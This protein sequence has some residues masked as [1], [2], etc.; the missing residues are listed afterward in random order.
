MPRGEISRFRPEG[1]SFHPDQGNYP[2]MIRFILYIARW[3]L[4]TPIMAPVIAFFTHSERM[5][6]TYQEW[7]AT[8]LGNLLGAGLFF[9]VDRFIFKSEIVESLEKK[10]IEKS[11]SGKYSKYYGT[12]VRLLLYLL[13][14]QL[15][16]LVVAP[17]IAYRLNSGSIF[18]SSQEWFATSMA[19]IVGGLIF[20]WVDKFIFKNQ[21]IEHWDS[22]RSGVCYDCGK[23]GFVRRL[24]Y[25]PGKY[26]RRDD[27]SP[28][29][30]CSSCSRKKL[31]EVRSRINAGVA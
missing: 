18:G 23:S 13:R 9:W 7:S 19:N 12:G 6:G 4:S 22:I 15:T 10:L 11:T 27:K 20:F 24:V 28:Q 2:D 3:Q 1:E 14:W 25:I 5:F 31:K 8:S 21:T 29:Y 26:D 17:V 30:R 16:T